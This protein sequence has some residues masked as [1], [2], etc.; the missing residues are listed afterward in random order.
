MYLNWEMNLK[1]AKIYLDSSKF[2]LYLRK[3]V[4]KFWNADINLKIS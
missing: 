3:R 4:I 2:Y 1:L